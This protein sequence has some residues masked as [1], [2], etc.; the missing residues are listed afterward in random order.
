[1]YKRSSLRSIDNGFSPLKYP[2][3]ISR[4]GHTLPRGV[5]YTIIKNILLYN[6]IIIIY[7]YH[8]VH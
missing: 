7:L 4:I 2:L 5:N 8:I 1:M 3:S 6:F